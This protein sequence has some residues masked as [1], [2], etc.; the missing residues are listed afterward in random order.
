MPQG[1]PESELIP[2]EDTGTTICSPK[3]RK[4]KVRLLPP[5]KLSADSIVEEDAP[6]AKS[7]VRKGK[8]LV[9]D[10][11]LPQGLIPLEPLAFEHDIPTYPPVIAQARS[12]M[13][14]YEN[15]VLLTRVGGFYELYFE[16]AEQYGPLLNLKVAVKRANDKRPNAAPIYMVN[17]R[18]FLR[19]A[20]NTTRLAFLSFS[21]TATSKFSSRT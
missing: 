15:C 8:I 11:E 3:T 17:R 5:E 9:R 12:N 18:V 19:Y 6:S 4:S 16:H 1:L 2:D 7:S 13:L 14:K 21:L 10:Q 20:S